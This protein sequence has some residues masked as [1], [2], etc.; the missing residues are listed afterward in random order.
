MQRT[1]GVTTNKINIDL[2]NGRIWIDFNSVVAVRWQFS[3]TNRYVVSVW[4]AGKNEPFDF[5]LRR[6]ALTE[7]LNVTGLPQLKDD[8]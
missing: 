2:P 6:E 8:E 5:T 3:Q 1:M 4:I 7:L